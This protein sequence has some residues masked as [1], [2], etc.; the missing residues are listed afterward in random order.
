MHASIHMKSIELEGGSSAPPK[1]EGPEYR[2]SPVCA[3]LGTKKSLE[4]QH[5]CYP[6]T[7]EILDIMHG[8]KMKD[9]CTNTTITVILGYSENI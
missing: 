5:L 3:S 7:R 9:E 2:P 4:H 8:I 1:I 6:T